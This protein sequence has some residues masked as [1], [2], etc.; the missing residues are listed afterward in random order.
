MIP[1]EVVV[2]DCEETNRDGSCDSNVKYCVVMK[3][4]DRASNS[5]N[6][7][8]VFSSLEQEEE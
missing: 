7:F 8:I 5:M 3:S 2:D 6:F 1:V 4:S